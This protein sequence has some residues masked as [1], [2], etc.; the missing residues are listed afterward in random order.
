M[1]VA[2]RCSQSAV[3]S[4]ATYAPCPKIEPIC[5]PPNDCQTFCPSCMAVSSKSVRP[6]A[7]TTARGIGG[8]LLIAR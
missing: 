5:C 8:A 1:N 4:G 7:V 6:S 2:S 3:Q